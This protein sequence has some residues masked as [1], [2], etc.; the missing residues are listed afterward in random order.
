LLRCVNRTFMR[1]FAAATL[2][3]KHGQPYTSKSGVMLE[4]H[5]NI[6]L[7][8]SHTGTCT[9]TQIPLSLLI[10]HPKFQK[11]SVE[12]RSFLHPQTIYFCPSRMNPAGPLALFITNK[13]HNNLNEKEHHERAKEDETCKCIEFALCSATTV[14]L[15]SLW[16]LINY[17][18]RKQNFLLILAALSELTSK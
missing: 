12:S 2:A 5:A 14:R 9:H 18:A 6:T 8:N 10:P 15:R 1:H 11:Y 13:P 7:T 17:L 4:L 3:F 16:K